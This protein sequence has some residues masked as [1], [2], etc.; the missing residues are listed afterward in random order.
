MRFF[1]EPARAQGLQVTAHGRRT[2]VQ[3]PRQLAR[4]AGPLSQ[5]IDDAPPMRIGEGRERLIDG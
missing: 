5:K 3:L 4:S 1:D 2:E